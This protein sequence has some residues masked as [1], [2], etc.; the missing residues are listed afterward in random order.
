MTLLGSIP[1]CFVA[2][3]VQWQNALT[4]GCSLHNMIRCL[5]FCD[6]NDNV[7]AAHSLNRQILMEVKWDSGSIPGRGGGVSIAV[8]MEGRQIDTVQ[9]CETKRCLRSCSSMAE[10]PSS[11]WKCPFLFFWP[12]GWVRIPSRG[13]DRAAKFGAYFY[14]QTTAIIFLAQTLSA[15]FF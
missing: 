5:P 4:F 8:L 2:S 3:L 1:V 10:R 9:L 12:R 6:G 11:A 15:L 13:S 7:K 14:Y